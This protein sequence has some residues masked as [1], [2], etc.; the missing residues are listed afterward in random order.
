MRHSPHEG[1][2][3]DQP[4]ALP[5]QIADDIPRN[6]VD[7]ETDSQPALGRQ[8]VGKIETL[9]IALN[10]LVVFAQRYLDDQAQ[11]AIAVMIN[12]E[13]SRCST[14]NLE[15]RMLVHLSLDQIRKLGRDAAY[16]SQRGFDQR[17]VGA[18]L[19]V[20]RSIRHVGISQEPDRS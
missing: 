6:L 17:M 8:I 11:D 4:I 7:V 13:V 20:G 5:N 15:A 1:R 16:D 18:R 12:Q 19:R 2:R 14:S 9:R 3:C 10:E